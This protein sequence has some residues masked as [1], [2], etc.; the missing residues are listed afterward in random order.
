MEFFAVIKIKNFINIACIM[1][2]KFIERFCN[3]LWRPKWLRG[4]N[5]FGSRRGRPPGPKTFRLF[6]SRPPKTSRIENNYKTRP[7]QKRPGLSSW[8][9]KQEYYLAILAILGESI[10]WVLILPLAEALICL[11]SALIS[12]R[13]PT[14]MLVPL[15]STL[16]MVAGNV[17]TKF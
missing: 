10:L 9:G 1:S 2:G 5:A 16:V 6:P 14:D 11:S 12:F 17:G 15:V 7:D 13:T 4:R 3:K 8:Y